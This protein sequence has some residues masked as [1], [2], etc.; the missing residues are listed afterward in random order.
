M[1]GVSCSQPVSGHHPPVPA[2]IDHHRKLPDMQFLRYSHGQINGLGE[3]PG[4]EAGSV[5]FAANTASRTS[6]N[7][8]MLTTAPEHLIPDHP[9]LRGHIGQDDRLVV[10][11]PAGPAKSAPPGGP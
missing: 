1:L 5:L 8:R 3:N 10:R 7:G 6:M 4:L 11:V 2:V 9:A